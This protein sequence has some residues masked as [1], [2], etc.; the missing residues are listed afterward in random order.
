MPK[1]IIAALLALFVLLCAAF[2]LSD[3]WEDDDWDEDFGDDELE[4][5]FEEEEDRVDFR[6][7]S[8]YNIE[9]FE[10]D[11]FRYQKTDD[12]KGR[13]SFLRTA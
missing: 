12:G 4:E 6:T 7:M 1:R 3:D 8:G 13:I 5:G 10:C 9:T 11:G 2:A